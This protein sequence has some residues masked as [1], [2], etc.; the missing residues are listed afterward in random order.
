MKASSH[1]RKNVRMTSAK[2]FQ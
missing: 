2:K 1:A